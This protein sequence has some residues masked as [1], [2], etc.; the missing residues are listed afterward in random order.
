[1]PAQ[2]SAFDVQAPVVG[3]HE[4]AAQTSWPLES[5]T[6]G[7]PL[8]QSFPVEQVSPAWRHAFVPAS[9]APP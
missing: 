7:A 6:H 9:L 3:T 1:M 2:Q 4:V 5:G 8:Q